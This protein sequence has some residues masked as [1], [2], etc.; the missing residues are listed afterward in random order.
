MKAASSSSNTF[1]DITYLYGQIFATLDR[2]LG[3]LLQPG[4]AGRPSI[5]AT[6]K[7][8]VNYQQ[9]EIPLYWDHIN[10]PFNQSAT[11]ITRKTVIGR[12]IY[13]TLLIFTVSNNV[14]KFDFE[15]SGDRRPCLSNGSKI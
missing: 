8:T 9:V 14:Y 6:A 13:L 5:N 12:I 1:M 4:Q 11:E 3:T 7:I 10:R 2:D 15:Y